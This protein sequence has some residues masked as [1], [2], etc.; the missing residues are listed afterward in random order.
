MNLAG[1]RVWQQEF[2]PDWEVDSRLHP[3]AEPAGEG[4]M[5]R[6]D[7]RE[8]EWSQDRIGDWYADSANHPPTEYAGDGLMW[9]FVAGH[10]DPGEW[11]QVEI[12][13]WHV[14]DQFKRLAIVKGRFTGF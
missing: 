2:I 12:P 1:K 13:D 8:Q 9:D 5:W 7:S 11:Q 14:L 6:Y 4:M 3:P 10:G